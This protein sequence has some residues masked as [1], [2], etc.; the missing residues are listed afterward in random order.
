MQ[1]LRPHWSPRTK[2]T[3]VLLL[4][5]FSL[6]LLYRF[7]AAITPLILAVIL[8]Y[9][10]SPLVGWI[11]Q[12]LKIRRTLA[13]LLTYLA[14]LLV[15]TALIMVIIPPLSTQATGLNLDIAALLGRD[16]ISTWRLLHHRR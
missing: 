3:I 4:L 12:H 8:A 9:V 11:E 1:E 14:M 5:G 10:T 7:R 16:R 2:L 6:Y 15:L 13:I